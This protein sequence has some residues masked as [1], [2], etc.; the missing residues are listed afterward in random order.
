MHEHRLRQEMIQFAR[1]CYDR[2]LLVALDGNLSALLPSGDVLCTRSG[3]HKGLLVDEDLVVVSRSGKKLRGAGEPT[4][5]T[6]MHLACYDERPDIRA[7]IHAHPPLSVAFTI[8]NVSMARCVLPEV[9]L[10]LGTIPTVEYRTTGTQALASVIR[11]YIQKHDALLM[12]THGALCVGESLLQAFCNLETMEHTALVTKTARDLGGVKGIDPAEAVKLRA[13]GLKRYGG[14]PQA[15][16]LADE[17]NA[18]LPESCVSSSGCANPSPNGLAPTS[19]LR[20]ARVVEQALLSVGGELA[21]LSAS[22][23][24]RTTTAASSRSFSN[25]PKSES[26]SVPSASLESTASLESVIASAVIQRLTSNS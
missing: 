10:T 26:A 12:D 13:M 14:P 7:V 1:M 8:A 25:H 11:P 5:E 9:V 6:L 17:P 18:D 24:T 22:G 19:G 2:G 21:G 23:V 3:C 4:S 16:V 15:V 20:M